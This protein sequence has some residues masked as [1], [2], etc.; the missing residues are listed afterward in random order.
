M[1]DRN[2]LT[3][4]NLMVAAAGGGACAVA[5]AA[6]STMKGLASAIGFGEAFTSPYANLS[7]GD[8]ASWSAQRGQTFATADGHNLEVVGVHLFKPFGRR[9][10]GVS[11]SRA[12][13]VDFKLVSGNAMAVEKIHSV[14][15]PE[16]TPMDLYL[17]SAGRKPGVV[18][19][20][21]S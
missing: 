7:A 21:F 1:A 19:A 20:M 15:D 4:R 8:H 5:I 16:Q 9:V 13:A 17:T 6:P 18:R 10:Q 12:F 3:R 11:R 14:T 2:L